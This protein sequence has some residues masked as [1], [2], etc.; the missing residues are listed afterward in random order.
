MENSTI[1]ER[2]IIFETSE[3]NILFQ[4]ECFGGANWLNNLIENNI[5]DF[6]IKDIYV[7]GV[8]SNFSQCCVIEFCEDIS[9]GLKPFELRGSDNYNGLIKCKECSSKNDL[10]EFLKPFNE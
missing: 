1:K 3:A 5:S 2:Q 7:K 9:K 8:Q 10:P 4:L 6:D